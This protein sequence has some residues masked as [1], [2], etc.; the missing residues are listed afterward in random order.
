M[1]VDGRVMNAATRAV[2]AELSG[3]RLIGSDLNLAN[4]ATDDSTLLG[5]CPP[6]YA[7]RSKYEKLPWISA[8]VIVTRPYCVPHGLKSVTVWLLAS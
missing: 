4:S 3:F 7:V 6:L 2:V 1:T 8:Q 5:L